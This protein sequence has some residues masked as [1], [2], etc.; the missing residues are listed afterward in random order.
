MSPSND[1]IGPRLQW[2]ASSNSAFTIQFGGEQQR[3]NLKKALFNAIEVN[4]SSSQIFTAMA[5]T[6]EDIQAS[7]G[8]N[9]D[10]TLWQMGQKVVEPFANEQW[11]TSLYESLSSQMIE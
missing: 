6:N 11:M 9:G 10:V 4:T 2:C 1:I 3:Y 7:G 5:S 8:K